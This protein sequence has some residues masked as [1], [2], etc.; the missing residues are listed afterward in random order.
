VAESAVRSYC[1]LELNVP[2]PPRRA[3]VTSPQR[4]YVGQTVTASRFSVDHR[5]CWL[6]SELPDP[7]GIGGRGGL[8]ETFVI[9]ATQAREYAIVAPR[10][11]SLSTRV[12]HRNV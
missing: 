5:P 12:S 6:V 11:T 7:I 8:P 3:H 4:Q 10:T 2:R 9:A 1:K